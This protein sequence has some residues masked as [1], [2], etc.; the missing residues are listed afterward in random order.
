MKKFATVAVI[1][2]LAAFHSCTSAGNCAGWS[3]IRLKSK[4]ADYINKNDPGAE[5]GILSHNEHGEN[6]GCWKS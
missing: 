6:V 3:D 4:T 2:S 1:C 5:A